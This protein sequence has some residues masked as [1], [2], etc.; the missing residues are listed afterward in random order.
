MPGEVRELGLH[1]LG[2]GGGDQVSIDS[3]SRGLAQRIQGHAREA[4]DL[5]EEG[6]Q[7]LEESWDNI[8]MG[9]P[10]RVRGRAWRRRRP[11]Q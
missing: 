6:P 2:G 3:G 5:E 10:Q 4:E 7:L 8:R 1:L 9:P 11:S